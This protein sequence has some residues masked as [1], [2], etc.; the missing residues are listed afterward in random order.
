MTRWSLPVLLALVV[1]C[2]SEGPAP[3]V[4]D[5]HVD[6]GEDAAEDAGGGAD[7]DAVE[8]APPLDDAPAPED[9]SD[10]EDL[11][12]DADVAD[13]V[14]APPDDVGPIG[15]W[16][17]ILPPNIKKE[18][19]F[20]GVWVGGAET[21]LLA[22]VDGILVRGDT[23]KW[24]ILSEGE[25]PNFNGIWG[26][27]PSDAWAVGFA[28]A[29]AHWNGMSWTAP[30]GCLTDADCQDGDPCTVDVCAETGLCSHPPAGLPGCCGGEA[31]SA[32]FDAGLG[33][34]QVQDLY[35]D[36]PDKGGIVWSVVSTI[37][38]DGKPRYTSPPS[39]LYFGDPSAP[40]VG[41]GGTCPSFNNGKVVGASAT[42]PAIQLPV[43]G[44]V[45]ASFQ[46]Y[47][48]TEAG[49]S[50]D[51]V[52]LNVLHGANVTQVW[53]KKDAP[54]AFLPVTV[55]IS[56][57]SGQSIALQLVFD[58]VDSFGNEGEGVYVDDL[59]IVTHCTAAPTDAPTFGTLFDVWGSGPKD[60]WAVGVNGALAHY[61][62]SAWAPVTLGSQTPWPIRALG[63]ADG[64]LLAGCESG[65]VLQTVGGAF[66]EA[67]TPP[68]GAINAVWSGGSA[69]RWAVGAGGV[70][71]L[72]AGDGWT[73]LS[74]PTANALRGVWG[75]SSGDV[76]AVGDGGTI[77]HLVGGGFVPEVSGTPSNLR[78]VWTDGQ[79]AIAVGD[80]GVALHRSGNAW[81]PVATGTSQ[82]LLALSVRSAQDAWAVGKNGAIR[83][84]D[85]A[86]WKDASNPLSA[87][88]FGVY[89]GAPD[90]VWVVGDKG[91]MVHWD[92]D[93]YKQVESP[94]GEAPLYAVWGTGP[95]EV[96]AAGDGF[97]IRWNGK[98]WMSVATQ[99]APV[100]LRG[101]C[102]SGPDNVLVVGAGAVIFRWD[103]KNWAFQPIK[104]IVYA[105]GSTGPVSDQLHGC[106]ARSTDLMF[107]VGENGTIVEWDGEVWERGANQ[108][109]ASLRSVYAVT[110]A[111]AFAVGIG[112]TIVRWDGQQWQPMAS[113]SVATLFDIHG[114]TLDDITV[115][116]DIG[117]ILRFAPN[118]KALK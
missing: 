30:S 45:V 84:W 51:R 86:A 75:A 53:A 78:A 73:S 32:T 33:G 54:K 12:A 79:T 8:D 18:H 66:T 21:V 40:C 117:T 64:E 98:S 100:T 2:T 69:F 116:G 83:R 106:W 16:E 6:G 97:I 77:L 88:Y 85:G 110:D 13:D 56:K 10:T 70:I 89:A 114:S 102:G 108:H 93:E 38:A 107:A 23:T 52:A 35:A 26:T 39:A 81:T 105:D 60:L 76:Y 3:E 58:S 11:S 7:A 115:V 29:I 43:A 22:G 14:A 65:L 67:Q 59:V 36:V 50:F 118:P 25:W 61:S 68:S 72:D 17:Q 31:W 46:I 87:D 27:S 5:A 9:A 49:E 103:G 55:D 42:S 47:V 91:V 15:T 57:F 96:Y 24:S 28:G 94:F 99:G 104:P 44:Q 74:S 1:S 90:D 71:L 34:W 41:G 19:V 62:G 82:A 63:G 48:D 4:V 37:G 111:L 95:S 109:P 80:D 112:G 92:G 20:K 113:G 101:V